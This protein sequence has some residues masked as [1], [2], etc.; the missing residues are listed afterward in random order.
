MTQKEQIVSKLGKSYDKARIMKREKA[1]LREVNQ[2]RQIEGN[3]SCAEC[4][5][6]QNGWASVTL[7][8]FICTNCSQI[9]R[10]LGA[11]ISKVKS[12]MGTYVWCPDEIAAMKA[13]GNRRARAVF[14]G[15]TPS[16]LTIP[17]LDKIARD[18]YVRKLWYLP[19]GYQALEASEQEKSSKIAAS[20]MS[21]STQSAKKCH[22]KIEQQSKVFQQQA[23]QAPSN[24]Q[25]AAYQNIKLEQQQQPESVPDL[26][27]KEL[28]KDVAPQ[29]QKQKD[30]QKDLND[31]F[32]APPI[33]ASVQPA[34][35]HRG[36]LQPVSVQMK[37]PDVSDPFA[38]CQEIINKELE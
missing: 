13:M 35:Q 11:H 38:F 28:Q 36:K 32:A 4:G 3:G 6:S 2:I 14:G 29:Q 26:F 24:A 20:V 31:L 7:G 16:P 17:Q 23:V 34:S 37:K 15:P 19:G 21:A 25:Q 1:L 9:H 33:T 8:V 22:E 10:G 30:R 5:E 12:C 27:Q 18:K